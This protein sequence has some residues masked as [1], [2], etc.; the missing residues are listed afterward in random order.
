MFL[1]YL[2]NWM[3]EKTL[4]VGS[5][6]RYLA[7][8]TVGL[9]SLVAIFVYRLK[10]KLAV[11]LS[12]IFVVLNI[13]AANKVLESIST[14]RSSK[15]VEPIWNQINNQV[16]PD[17]KDIIFM[18]QGSDLVW[19]TS[20]NW[21]SSFPFAIKRGITNAYDLPIVT[22]DPKLVSELLCKTNVY[23][24]SVG[25]WVNQKNRI[26]I[27]HL[28]AWVWDGKVLIDIS[29]SERELFIKEAPC[30]VLP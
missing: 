13:I 8:A 6:H 10:P 26:P 12:I 20:M 25:G 28:Y 7:V 24:P 1:F 19:G 14:Y 2:P 17:Q 29:E 16:I 11:L 4:V 23:R 15:I 18:Y 30:K 27:S 22:G 21:A 3:Y 5:S 9:I